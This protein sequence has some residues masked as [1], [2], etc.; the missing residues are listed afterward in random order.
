MKLLFVLFAMAAIGLSS[1]EAMAQWTEV[2]DAGDL[3]GSAQSPVC[4]G[5]LTSISGSL[6]ASDVD[7]YCI[8]IDAGLPYAASVCGA[9]ASFDSQLWLFATTGNGIA[10][11]DDTCGDG[12]TQSRLGVIQP[13]GG[14]YLLAIS[15]FD[16]DALNAGGAA[17][18]NDADF[19]VERA[20]DGPGAPG[21]VA[22][23]AGTTAGPVSY[24]ISLTY[25]SCCGVTPVEPS[26]WGKI[27]SI[28][29]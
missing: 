9:G 10:F 6:G 5:P 1:P 29:R 4:T 12:S 8:H 7:M 28:Y 24:T 2:G 11:G 13:G 27:K 18:W 16:R 23:W 25:V 14:D 17:I 21:P 15:R 19:A 22:S 26:T 3:P 20:P